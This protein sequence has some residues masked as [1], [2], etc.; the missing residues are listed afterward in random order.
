LD[1]HTK[2]LLEAQLN[3]FERIEDIFTPKTLLLRLLRDIVKIPHSNMIRELSP[4]DHAKMLQFT[5]MG[6]RGFLKK[7][8]ND[9]DFR[10]TIKSKI[11]GFLSG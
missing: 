7:I 4:R 1:F 9:A 10:E 8:H 5:A 3:G 2:V 11:H 6:F